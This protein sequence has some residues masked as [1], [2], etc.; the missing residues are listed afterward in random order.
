MRAEVGCD[1]VFDVSDHATIAVQV[2]A[3]SSAAT[4]EVEEFVVALDTRV[5]DAHELAVD[6]G[7]RVHMVRCDTGRLTLRYRAVLLVAP[8]EEREL[9][10]TETLLALRQ[11]RYCP[12]DALE[13]FAETEL[14]GLPDDADRG[15][16]I[17]DWVHARLRNEPGSSGPLDDAV[18]TLLAGRGVCRDFAHLTIALCRAIGL[19]ARLVS[20]YAP[21]LS[22]MDFHAIAEVAVAGGWEVVDATRAAPR[23]SLVRIATGR[24][25]ADT[26]LCTTIAGSVELVASNVNAIVLGALP[27]DD[28]RSAVAVS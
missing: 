5:L 1:L 24:D 10:E 18:D 16:A 19:P 8:P 9:D 11:S 28:H 21:G 23:Q 6:H 20:V 3:A 13:G 12:S 25:A 26:A 14:G 7:G 15:R 22:P 17:G 2:A 27:V 4:I